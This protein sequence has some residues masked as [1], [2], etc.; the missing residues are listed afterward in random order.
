MRVRFAA[1]EPYDSGMLDVTDGHRL[2]WECCGNP[3]G[4]AAFF[5]MAGRFW[6]HAGPASVL[7]SQR[8]PHCAVRPTRV[9]RSR[10][11][12]NVDLST[13]TTS[14]LIADIERLRQHHGVESWTILEELFVYYA[15]VLYYLLLERAASRIPVAGFAQRLAKSV[16]WQR[17][18]STFLRVPFII[19]PLA[20]LGLSIAFT[21]LVDRARSFEPA[22]VTSRDLPYNS[23][24]FTIKLGRR[25]HARSRTR[26]LRRLQPIAY[27]CGTLCGDAYTKA[28]A[29][30]HRRHRSRDR[31]IFATSF[32]YRTLEST[33]IYSYVA[34]ARL[35]M[36]GSYASHIRVSDP[37]LRE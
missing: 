10:P 13:N 14:H 4:K 7:R 27:A 33:D 37:G 30:R 2:Y 28:Q 24:M 36:I 15:F 26:I 20:L 23:S 25:V 31:R 22:D 29:I 17:A 19:Y 16:L 8:L 21:M 9:R 1:I 3:G 32:L 34:N 12:A 6:L 11:L 5:G 35:G 18:Y